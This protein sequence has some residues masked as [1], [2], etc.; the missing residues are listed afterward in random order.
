VTKKLVGLSLLF[1]WCMPWAVADDAPPSDAQIE[2]A[3]CIP[4]LKIM[5]DQ[6]RQMIAA[7]TASGRN[8]PA[9]VKI[10]ADARKAQATVDDL[11]RQR[12]KIVGT[13]S[14]PNVD[15][16]IAKAEARALADEQQYD[17]SL[18]RCIQQ[19]MNSPETR[20]ACT[21]SCMGTDTKNFVARVQACKAPSTPPH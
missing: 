9:A 18:R 4:L 8:D 1:V 16:P 19:C 7:L 11:L 2:S 21:D 14:P 6:Q 13:P 17:S 20:N 5:S 10:L 3:Y 12:Q 15:S